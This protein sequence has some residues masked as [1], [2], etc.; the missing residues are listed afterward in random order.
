MLPQLA[1]LQQRLVG[2]TDLVQKTS[3]QTDKVANISQA[4]RE[5][6]QRV[7][8]RTEG[9]VDGVQ[10]NIN[11]AFPLSAKRMTASGRKRTLNP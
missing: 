6:W 11:P 7:Q 10:H 1:E 5:D 2:L 8:E 4:L 3:K 9:R